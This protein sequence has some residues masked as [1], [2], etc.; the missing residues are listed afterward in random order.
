MVTSVIDFRN[1][2]GEYY[3]LTEVGVNIYIYLGKHHFRN[4]TDVTDLEAT[5]VIPV[6]H[7]GSGADI[8]KWG[9]T[10]VILRKWVCAG[11]KWFLV[12]IR[13]P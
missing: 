7:Y 11:G 5:S 3:G 6:H 1:P 2:W 8:R 12:H 9:L 13:N 10:S 4:I